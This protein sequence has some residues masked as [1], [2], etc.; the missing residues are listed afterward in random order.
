MS[1][2]PLEVRVPIT[3]QPNVGGEKLTIPTK[4]TRK[5]NTKQHGCL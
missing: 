2:K 3:E 1:S 4:E 5:Q